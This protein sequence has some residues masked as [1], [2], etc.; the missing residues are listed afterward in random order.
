MKQ[1]IV[2]IAPQPRINIWQFRRSYKII[3]NRYLCFWNWKK[4]SFR[5]TR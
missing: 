4:T 2:S 3:S 1:E 5:R